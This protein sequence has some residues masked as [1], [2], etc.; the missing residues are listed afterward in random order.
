M[1]VKCLTHRE[2]S[3]LSAA[4]AQHPGPPPNQAQLTLAHV[5]VLCEPVA[6]VAGTLH[7]PPHHLAL[8]GTATV[9][10]IA[11]LRTRPGPCASQ[12]RDGS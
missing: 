6:C 3:C 10:H 1:S 11:V 5:P 9:V 4:P 2:H 12:A 8:L 7:C